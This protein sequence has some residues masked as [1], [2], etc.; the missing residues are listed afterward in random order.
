MRADNTT[1]TY[2]PAYDK[3][4]STHASIDTAMSSSVHFHLDIRLGTS[5]HVPGGT[6]PP[7]AFMNN[8]ALQ[9]SWGRGYPQEADA[10]EGSTRPGQPAVPVPGS[11][12]SPCCL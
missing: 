11:R 10:L 12:P 2:S 6:H 3:V 4:T 5:L 7:K 9:G 1:Y 8:G